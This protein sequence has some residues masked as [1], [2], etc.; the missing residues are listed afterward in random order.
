MTPIGILCPGLAEVKLY[1]KKHYPALVILLLLVCVCCD[2]PD[3]ALLRVEAEMRG[4]P[5]PAR[6]LAMLDSVGSAG[7]RD[8][9]PSHVLY[10][11]LR[12]ELLLKNRLPLHTDSMLEEAAAYYARRGERLHHAEALH[13]SS[14][15]HLMQSDYPGA[16]RRASGALDVASSIPDTLLMARSHEM[17]ANIYHSI[18][19]IES[20]LPH[21]RAAN[22]LYGRATSNTNHILSYLFL[23]RALNSGEYVRDGVALLDSIAPL[24]DGE[25]DVIRNYYLGAYPYALTKAGDNARLKAMMSHII[26]GRD[27]AFTLDDAYA[28][29]RM[30]IAEGNLDSAAIWKERIMPLATEP[31]DTSKAL[32]VQAYYYSEAGDYRKALEYYNK[33]NVL[34]EDV[35]GKALNHSVDRAAAEHYR[36]VAVEKDAALKR[37][38]LLAAVLCVAVAVCLILWWLDVRR[39]KRVLM[40]RMDEIGQSREFLDSGGGRFSQTIRD[41]I[42]KYLEGIIRLY[43]MQTTLPSSSPE[44]QKIQRRIAAE[45]DALSSDEVRAMVIRA[46]NASNDGIVDRL[47]RDFPRLKPDDRLVFALRACRV[48]SQIISLFLNVQVSGYYS[49]RTR[50]IKRIE[51]STSP[52][53]EIYLRLL[54]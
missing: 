52:H 14:L 33:Q 39:R 17:I 51:G 26:T 36:E 25:P 4:D 42:R 34:E 3:G 41:L 40:N 28:L 24:F 46:V 2:R 21:R 16:M 19:N 11:L 43:E 15:W 37:H 7:F 9:R 32:S 35:V 49:R 20:E 30:Y 38:V 45:L 18:Y 48:P 44:A 29:S 53:K 47:D 31:S 8:N 50:L 10:G 1:A 54:A 6:A 27:S 22:I 5:Y 23:A 13:Y 12:S